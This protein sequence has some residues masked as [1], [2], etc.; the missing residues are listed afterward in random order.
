MSANSSP[1]VSQAR[2]TPWSR[3]GRICAQLA[4]G[5]AVLAGLILG[6]LQVWT[7]PFGLLWHLLHGSSILYDG[8]RIHVPYDMWVH[9]FPNG[10]FVMMH[11]TARYAVLGAR[12]GVVMFGRTQ[13]PVMDVS[14]YY[15]RIAEARERPRAGYKFV[16]VRQIPGAKGIVYCWES[17]SLDSREITV[18]CTFDKDTLF[19][20]FAG[21]RAYRDDVYNAVQ[22][23]AGAAEK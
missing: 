10:D 21:S 5:A 17:D 19:A 7:T 22:A 13:G 16:G 14:K 1:E 4:A 18:D 9:R 3:F 2:I 12:S 20:R 8:R 23:V 15:D 6:G 11:Q